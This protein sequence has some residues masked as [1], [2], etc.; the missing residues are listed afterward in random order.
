M[1]P[2]VI[3][4]L[5]PEKIHRPVI[6]TSSILKNGSPQQVSTHS[7]QV[8][9]L[10]FGQGGDFVDRC[11]ASDCNFRRI[12][13]GTEMVK[14]CDLILTGVSRVTRLQT[15]DVILWLMTAKTAATVLLDENNFEHDTQAATGATTGDWFVM[16]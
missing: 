7:K 15:Q 2:K 16:L 4:F 1:P 6:P 10:V 13:V 3:K 11:V 14:K 8:I 12:Y 9:I 5:K